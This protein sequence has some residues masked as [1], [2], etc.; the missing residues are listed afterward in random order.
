[1]NLSVCNQPK[2][3]NQCFLLT[4]PQSPRARETERQRE[5]EKVSEDEEAEG[6]INPRLPY[7]LVL[8]C[9]EDS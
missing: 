3:Y 7:S 2:F 8:G 9:T 6:E 5:A 4:E 1:M